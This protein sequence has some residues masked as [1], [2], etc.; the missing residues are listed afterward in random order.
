MEQ[1]TTVCPTEMVC[2]HSLNLYIFVSYHFSMIF[3]GIQFTDS[4]SSSIIKIV[5]FNI[6]KQHQ[7]TARSWQSNILLLYRLDNYCCCCCHFLYHHTFDIVPLFLQIPVTAPELKN[8]QH[9][10]SNALILPSKKRKTKDVTKSLTPKKLLSKKQRKKLE[11]IVQR[12]EKKQKVFRSLTLTVAH[13]P[14][15]FADT[16]TADIL[17]NLHC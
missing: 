5:I 6:V 3:K 8:Q 2:L 11:Q 13:N 17:S 9:D 4:F 7:M 12:K 16:Q 1:I 15:C 10:D 14:V